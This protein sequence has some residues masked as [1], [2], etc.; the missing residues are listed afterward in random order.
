MFEEALKGA[1]KKELKEVLKKEEEGSPSLGRRSIGKTKAWLLSSLFLSLWLGGQALPGDVGEAKASQAL[2]PSDISALTSKLSSQNRQ[3]EQILVTPE[4]PG[5]NRVRY[6]KFDWRYHDYLDTEGTGGVRLYFYEREAEIAKIAA[7]LVREQYDTL[8]EKF[9]YRPSQQIPYILY[10]SHR[11][12][13]NTNIFFVDEYILGVTSPLDLRMALPYWGELERFR[14]VSTHE[15]V[16]QF[17]IQKVADRAAA[18]GLDNPVMRMPLWFIEGLAEYY[19][20]DGID[21]ETD[22]FARDLLL[23]PDP[24]RGYVLIDF[25]LDVPTAFIYTYKL[26]QLR[27]AFLAET[28]GERMVQ[29]VL[30]QSPRLASS[31]SAGVYGEE[32]S[33]K[34]EFK[35][36]VSRLAEESPEAISQRFA[37]WI[38]RRYLPTYLETLQ[39]PP[40]ISP[41]DLPGEPDAFGVAPDGHTLLYRSVE[42]ET[43]RSRLFLADRR[44]PDDAVVVAVDG[45]PGIESLH[46]VLRSVSTVGEERIAYFGRHGPGDR[47]HV[48]SYEKQG[49]GAKTRL[50]VGKQKTFDLAKEGIIEA[51]DP[52]FAPDG[53]RLAFFGL[54]L[55]GQIDLWVI[56]TDSGDLQRL[57]NDLYAER[58]VSWSE[59]DPE[60]FGIDTSSASGPSEGTLIFSSDATSHRKYNLMAMDPRTKVVR[61]LS[62]EAAD[63][64]SAYALGG[65]LVVFSTDAKLKQDLHLYDANEGKIRRLT[66]FVTGLSNP[67]PGM[68]GL[69]ALGFYGGKFQIFDVPT[70]ALL[71]LDERPALSSSPKEPA[72]FPSEAIPEEVPKYRPLALRNWRLQNGA[73]AVGTAN[74]GQGVLLFGD[75]LGDRSLLLQLSVFGSFE[76]TDGIALFIDRSKRSLYGFGPFHTFTQRR[77]PKA[78]GFLG[79]AIYLQREF[80]LT[81]VWSYPFGAFSRMEARGVLQGVSRQFSYLL[82]ADRF[83]APYINLGELRTWRDE[84]GGMDME[85]LLSLRYGYDT[86][87]YRFPGGAY[88]GGSFLFELGTGVLPFQRS[89]DRWHQF[90]ALD[91]QYHF[92]LLG[93]SFHFR[94]AGGWAGGSVFGRQFFLSSFDNLRGY[95]PSD[96]RLLGSAYA[97]ANADWHLPLDALIRLAFLSHVAAVAGVDVGAVGE[98]FSQVIERR[99]LAGVLGLNLGF[100]AFELRVHFARPFDIGGDVPSD[101]WVPNVSLRYLYF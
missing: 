37:A 98:S 58:D 56:D 48:R 50:V 97:V 20:K 80:G 90:A 55:D 75:S 81:G 29:A 23:N 63:Q 77:D 96:T 52:S 57:S 47:L 30:D 32:S 34:D 85:G 28:Y 89:G 10:N 64:R 74:V 68:R 40:T 61:Q 92:R 36:L 100:G 84:R 1:L 70:D 79:E 73:A 62:D 67:A 87:R 13:E 51:G 59:D 19:S 46:P 11:E 101:G 44:N 86:T 43:G 78:P 22:M 12:F 8:V 49:R 39:E 65:G 18:L 91:S 2:W 3:L 31:L 6:Y 17:T 24:F 9:A 42:R 72:P 66:D 53:V 94:L 82:D 54:D 41:V 45:K 5:R 14:E 76:L 26:G 60:L 27:V 15:M 4:R 95:H 69:M 33:E 71:E 16:H 99:S 7:A 21:K 38:K 35:Q 88:G 83:I 25:W 93:S